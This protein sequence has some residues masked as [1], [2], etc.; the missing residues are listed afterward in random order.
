MDTLNKAQLVIGETNYWFRSLYKL[1]FN[2]LKWL[3][4]QQRQ[5][6][7]IIKCILVYKCRMG[8]AQQYVYS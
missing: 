6:F 5:D 2:K 7:Y 3:S 1:M 4:L 8:L